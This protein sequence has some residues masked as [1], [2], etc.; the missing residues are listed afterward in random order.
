YAKHAKQGSRL[1]TPPTFGIYVMGQVFK[2]LLANGGLAGIEQHNDAKAKL[3]YDVIDGSGGFYRGVS[4]PECRSVMNVSF[5]TPSDELDKKF[6]AEASRHD[7]DGLKGHRDAGGLR[8][9]I[10]NAFPHKGC[11]MLAQFMT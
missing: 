5:R 7:M 2:W 4:R 1:N 3:I 11:E 6:L 10:Y 8:A 9:S